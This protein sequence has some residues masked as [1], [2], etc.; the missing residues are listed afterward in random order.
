MACKS[1]FLWY[2]VDIMKNLKEIVSENIVNLRKRDS[3]TQ[4]ELGKKINYS[5]KAIS[6]WENGEVL[7]DLETLQKV[8]EIFDVPLSELLEE[9]DEKKEKADLVKTEVLSQIFLVME[10]WTIVCAVY[11][12]FNMAQGKNYWDIF[13]AGVPMSALIL[14]FVNRKK[15]NVVSFVYGTIFVWSF[16]TCIFLYLL[17]II[18]WYL[19]IIGVPIQGILIIRYLFKFKQRNILKIRSRKK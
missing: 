14:F 16:L 9:R 4:A 6:R 19:F 15:N 1:V 3:L 2:N 10:I 8:A 11:A 17:P 13:L 12:Y 7:P 18:T 5:D